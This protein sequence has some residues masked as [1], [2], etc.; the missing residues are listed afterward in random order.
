MVNT[1]LLPPTHFPTKEAL[2]LWLLQHIEHP[3]IRRALEKGK[4]W[5]HTMQGEES[6]WYIQCSSPLGGMYYLKILFFPNGLKIKSSVD[7]Q[8]LCDKQFQQRFPPNRRS[9]DQRPDSSSDSNPDISTD[10]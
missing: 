5:V 3:S 2:R 4:M 7:L 1:K 6:T 10:S 8:S 9:E